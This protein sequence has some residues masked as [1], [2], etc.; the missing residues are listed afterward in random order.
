[1]EYRGSEASRSM[2]RRALLSASVG[3]LA[4]LA[5]AAPAGAQTAPAD[6]AT[7][8]ASAPIQAA[9]PGAADTGE[10]IVTGSR[11][12]SSGFNAPTP[13]Q[14]LGA[15]D[16]ARDV[17]AH[18]RNV[19]GEP[20][21]LGDHRR[22]NVADVVTLARSEVHCVP[23]QRAAVRAFPL[24]IG[25]GK[26]HAEVAERQRAE[27]RIGNRMQ[28]DVGVGMAVET[29][30][31][32]D[33]DAADDQRAAGDQRMDVETA[34]DTNRHRGVP[35]CAARIDAASAMSSG[36]VIFRFATLPRT[37]FGAW[38]AASIACASSVAAS[39]DCGCS[40]A[41]SSP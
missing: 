26:V 16:I 29:A 21:R 10:V 40:A 27:N 12:R 18:R 41:R 32:R 20:G 4:I 15:A 23:E 35:S 2:R 34:A 7:P 3:A 25:V 28:Q 30:L 19:G 1:M 38:P 11:I 14:V 39:A 8:P 13:T 24:R 9:A 33:G 31:E 6:T 5:L 36:Y 17:R 37:S 22:V